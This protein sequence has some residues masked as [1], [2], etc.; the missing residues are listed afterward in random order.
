[1]NALTAKKPSS[2]VEKD[3]EEK[4][5][6]TIEK[7]VSVHK[8]AK[9][10][11]NNDQGALVKQV[12]SLLE[13]DVPWEVIEVT[14]EA[15]IKS[16]I[17]KYESETVLKDN[18][19]SEITLWY[20]FSMFI[21]MTLPHS[22]TTDTIYTRTNS[23]NELKWVCGA[24]VPYGFTARIL[25]FYITSMVV[26]YSIKEI[27]LGKSRRS[28]LRDLGV[29]TGGS[30]NKAVKE[31]LIRLSESF[32][33][34]K[35]I[36]KMKNSVKC[37]ELDNIRLFSKATFWWDKDCELEQGVLVVSDE[38]YNAIKEQGTAAPFNKEIIQSFSKCMD[39]DV[40]TLISYRTHKSCPQKP[41]PWSS[42]MKQVGAGYK[43]VD[44]FK[45]HFIKSLRH[46]SELM[47]DL[48]LTPLDNGLKITRKSY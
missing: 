12:N 13:I 34:L 4:Y 46:I 32:L 43:K 42:L 26:K 19:E 30:Q 24:G 27:P 38:F 18:D 37:V 23:L 5:S 7:I 48:Q 10:L 6:L 9:E 44:A 41:I 16:R 25:L 15:F 20:M 31:Q 14:L 17:S 11:T 29:G 1:M 47:P 28:L 40:Y 22:N 33:T 3:K 2:K 8:Q 35:N 36:K 39:L 45:H 21:Q